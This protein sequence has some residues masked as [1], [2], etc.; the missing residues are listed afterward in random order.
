[1]SIAY[2]AVQ[3]NRDKLV[4][5][6]LVIAA[7]ALYI[8]AFLAV[9]A[10]LDP[11][12]DLLAEIDLRIRAFGSCAFLM[13]TAILSIGPLARLDRR[14]LPLLYNRRH[15]GVLT[16]CVAATHFWFMIEWY[17][18]MDALPS[19]GTE[20]TTWSDYGKFIGFPF[21]A[22]GIAALLVLF[23]MASTSHDFW[24]GFLTSPAWKALHMALYAAYGLLVMHV[25]LGAMQFERTPLLPAMLIGGFATVSGLHLVAGWRERTLDRGT[26]VG[27]D[28]WLPVGP[29]QSIPDQGA[30]IVAEPGGERIAVFRDGARIGAL[31]NLCA[32]QNGP[33]GEGRIIDGCV[34]CPWHGYQ[35]RLRDGCAPPPFTE[36]LATYRVRLRDGLVE[37]DP[38][39]L[40]PGTPAAI[41]C[42]PG[43]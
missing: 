20:L 14:F 19:L 22:L 11:P 21:K 39:P 18:V 30:R 37:V 2:R 16:F 13:L 25:A 4:Y 23:L 5:D 26:P 29:P 28:G 24:L 34:T 43:A 8:A 40:P 6:G 10:R 33:I 1:M 27:R 9:G 31:T 15:L 32:H 17:L 3:W 12:K 42:P 7:V 41:T 36:K 38:R 35:Y